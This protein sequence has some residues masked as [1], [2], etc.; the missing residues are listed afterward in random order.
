MHEY[1]IV[2]SLIGR[3]ERE[4]NLRGAARVHRLR[5]AI[6]ELAGVEVELLRTAYD[7]FRERTVCQ[8]A[9]LDVATVAARWACPV[10]D[11]EVVPGGILRCGKCGRPAHLA[12]GDEI[13]L[14]QIELEVSDV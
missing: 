2:A 10:C 7:T 1:S 12:R 4:A 11:V 8:D 3:A 5:V 9:D 13:V 14:E 6:G